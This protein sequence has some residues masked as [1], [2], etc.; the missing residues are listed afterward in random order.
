MVIEA[1]I[2]ELTGFEAERV[3]NEKEGYSPIIFK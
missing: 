1:F 3:L 2:F